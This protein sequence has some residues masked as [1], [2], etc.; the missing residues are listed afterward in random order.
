M[1]A[2]I[3]KLQ[4]ADIDAVD[5]LMKRYRQTLGFL[6]REALRIY[7]QNGRV[8]G[9]TTDDHQLVGYLLYGGTRDYFRITHLCVVEEHRG[10]GIAKQLLTALTESATTQKVVRLSCRRDFPAHHMWPQLGFV[11]VH[12]RRGRSADG[13]LLTLWSLTLAP[14]NQLDLFRAQT[15]DEALDV[16]IDSQIF[17]DLCQPTPPNSHSSGILHA[18]FLSESVHLWITDELLVEVDRKQDP[19]QREHS[20]QRAQSFSSIQY[21]LQSAEQYEKSLKEVLPSRTRSQKSDIRHL[22]RSAASELHYFVTR[23]TGI[24]RHAEEISHRTGLQILSPTELVV[25]VHELAEREAYAAVPISGLGLNWR[26]L[27]SEDFGSLPYQSFLETDEQLRGFRQQIAGFLEIPNRFVCQVLWSGGQ[28]Q[29]L[30]VLERPNEDTL[31]VHVGRAASSPSRT[32]FETFLIADTVQKAVQDNIKLIKV[33]CVAVPNRAQK[34]LLK[35]GFT[36]CDGGFVRFCL[37]EYT[38]RDDVLANTAHLCADVSDKLKHASDDDLEGLCSPLALATA[39]E[40][41]FLVP[42]RPSFAM[43]LFDQRH[44]ANDLFG[45]NTKVLLRWDN[46][47]YRH[48]THHK[49]LRPPARILWYVSQHRR[50]IIAISR[51]D[52]VEVDTP[53]SL[54]R[55]FKR[56]GVLRWADIFE[57][58]DG[59]PSN[60]IM[61]IQFSHTFLLR[62][63]VSLSCLRDVFSKH[64]KGLSLQSPLSIPP[65]V[66]EELFKLGYPSRS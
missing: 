54:F 52:A 15:V 41:Y 18:D 13:H 19:R 22:A 44:A 33:P 63:P 59:D 27:S 20:R 14:D 57:L 40:K 60:K 9:A 39:Q 2:T 30:R 1:G 65:V 36:N 6:P 26:R 38:R 49:I 10:Q 17:F 16:V 61:A 42:I 55:K 3:T 35:L 31:I 48:K 46:V 32:L 66:F 28:A 47:Y 53:K 56:F 64:G 23:D 12:E 29:A 21:D 45:G 7:L 24:L 62:E 51:L 5:R 34:D 11:P 8:L 25:H 4:S 37:P 58:C 50:E 43:S